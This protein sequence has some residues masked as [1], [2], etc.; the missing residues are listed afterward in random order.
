MHKVR[1]NLKELRRLSKANSK[2]RKVI[3]NKANDDLIA[4]ICEIAHN[5]LNRNV[6]LSNKQFTKLRK[7]KHIVRRLSKKGESIKNKRKIIKQKGGFLPLL[8]APLL[9]ALATKL[10]Y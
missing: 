5:T 9:A 1:Q 8:I 3:I 2:Q 4:S 6:P 10:F 7:H